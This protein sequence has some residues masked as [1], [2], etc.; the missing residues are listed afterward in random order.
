LAPLRLDLREAKALARL[1]RGETFVVGS[2]GSGIR[3]VT[4]TRTIDESDSVW[5]ALG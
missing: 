5:P 1:G 3:S 4:K 2:D